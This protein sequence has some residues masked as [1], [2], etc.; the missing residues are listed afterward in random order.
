MYYIIACRNIYINKLSGSF[1]SR[2]TERA[3]GV[4]GSVFGAIGGF[5][6]SCKLCFFVQVGKVANTTD[7]DKVRKKSK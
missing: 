2:V 1:M 5:I 4:A 3:V 6:T 7:I